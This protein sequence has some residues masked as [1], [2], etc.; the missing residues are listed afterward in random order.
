MFL[1]VKRPC[2]S[3]ASTLA[4]S[5]LTDPQASIKPLLHVV[6]LRV[7][8]LYKMCHGPPGAMLPE[9]FEVF[10]PIEEDLNVLENLFI[11]GRAL[12]VQ[13]VDC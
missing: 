10:R 9:G 11:S 5:F 2:A 4:S 13:L 7:H 12:K 6:S 1:D 3:L 8:I